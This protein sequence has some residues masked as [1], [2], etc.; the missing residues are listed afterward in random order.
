MLRDKTKQL[1]QIF[2]DLETKRLGTAYSEK[3]I[4]EKEITDQYFRIQVFYGFVNNKRGYFGFF[5]TC[6]KFS[7]PASN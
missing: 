7:N 6:R 1:L 2:V 4:K 3:K 5:S